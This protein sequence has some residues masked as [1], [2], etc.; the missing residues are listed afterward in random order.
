MAEEDVATREE[1]VSLRRQNEVKRQAIKDFLEH[2]V[3]FAVMGVVDCL[4]LPYTFIYFSVA[5]RSITIYNFVCSSHVLEK[6]SCCHRIYIL[7][8]KDQFCAPP[9]GRVTFFSVLRPEKF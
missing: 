8:L 1:E 4:F 7:I 3:V 9:S 6:R 2:V 5:L